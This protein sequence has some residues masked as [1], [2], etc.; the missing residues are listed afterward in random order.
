[1]LGLYSLKR[2]EEGGHIISTYECLAK[3]R[4]RRRAQFHLRMNE[5]LIRKGKTI[6]RGH[7]ATGLRCKSFSIQ[8]VNGR[9][10]YQWKWS[11]WGQGVNTKE[12]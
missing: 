2:P 1:M 9:K 7:A 6:A 12:D 5:I 4:G 10:S 11:R 3:I 8:V